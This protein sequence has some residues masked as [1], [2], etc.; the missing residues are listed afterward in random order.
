MIFN[1][2]FYTVCFLL[3]III[4]VVLFLYSFYCL[5]FL[6]RQVVRQDMQYFLLQ[7]LLALGIN[8]FQLSGLFSFLPRL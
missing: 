1:R 5:F 7:I 2:F 8:I 3:N 6:K 4:A